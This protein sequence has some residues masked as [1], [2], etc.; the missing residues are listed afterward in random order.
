MS[1]RRPEAFPVETPPPVKEAPRRAPRAMAAPKIEFEP[2]D[3]A[4]DALPLPAPPP[5]RRWRLGTLLAAALAGLVS[6]YA[7]L[8]ATRLIEDLFQRS[9]AFGWI[10]LALA[11]LAAAAALAIIAR[12][13]WGLA[14][15]SRIQGIQEDAARALGANDAAAA[16][17]AIQ[18]LKRLY[19]GRRDVAWGLSAV[20]EHEAA[21]MDAADR[22]R[23]AD[24]DLLTP[25]DA[26]SHRVIARAARRIALLTT[27]TPAAALDIVFVAAQNLRMVR[28]LATLY[29]GRPSTLAT[30]RLARMALS[31]LAVAG[32]LALSDSLVQH[33][34]GKGL[35]GRLSARFGEGAVNGILTAR[36]GLAARDVCRPFPQDPA[37]RETLAAL[38]REVLSFDG[39]EEPDASRP[40]E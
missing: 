16:Q 40:A 12:E 38:V 20:A 10:A 32:G 6:L 7:G 33:L 3:A 2:E 24:R 29:G 31:H 36:I 19:A 11:G 35:V 37:A 15:L 39:K 30:L 9:A 26:E 14:R 21:I 28:E 5:R 4:Q 23:L 34:L 13:V 27:I 25:L 22:I 18:S 17:R 8:A 1:A